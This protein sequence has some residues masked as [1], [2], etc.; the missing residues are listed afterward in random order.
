MDDIEEAEKYLREA[1][2]STTDRKTRFLLRA[3]LGEDTRFDYLNGH[4]IDEGGKCVDTSCELTA[5]HTYKKQ[6]DEELS[7]E[8]LEEVAETLSCPAHQEGIDVRRP[9]YIEE[10]PNCGNGDTW[11]PYCP[12]CGMPLGG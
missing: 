10:C 2:D 3:A 4:V 5:P 7:M 12:E 6:I 1:L 8:W 9:V 11:R